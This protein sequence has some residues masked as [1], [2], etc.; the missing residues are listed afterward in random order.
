[1][2]LENP[3]QNLA[4]IL[5]VLLYKRLY[6]LLYKQHAKFSTRFL[7]D[8]RASLK[9]P[10]SPTGAAATHEAAAAHG[11]A[12]TRAPRRPSAPHGASQRLKGPRLGL[13]AGRAA[14]G[15][16]VVLVKHQVRE[17]LAVPDHAHATVRLHEDLCGA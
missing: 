4:R 11:A 6:V 7:K 17:V 10:G 3:L 13:L 9:P 12:L 16:P 2:G 8:M 14:P 1:M 5:Y 15:R